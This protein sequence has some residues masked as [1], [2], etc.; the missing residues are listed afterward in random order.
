MRRAEKAEKSPQDFF[1]SVHRFIGV[2]KP[3]K[4]ADA[5]R[6]NK[7]IADN[8]AVLPGVVPALHPKAPRA[9]RSRK[10][11]LRT[12][13]NWDCREYSTMNRER[14]IVGRSRHLRQT[15]EN[16]HFLRHTLTGNNR[17]KQNTPILIPPH[18]ALRSSVRFQATNPVRSLKTSTMQVWRNNAS[19]IF[20]TNAKH[21]I[22]SQFRPIAG[23]FLT[24]F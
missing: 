15:R 12:R 17:L 1:P 21:A 13:S 3:D 10:P 14:P 24:E 18:N 2:P 20:K 19:C 9:A 11:A 16:S 7:K 22:Q 4:Q 6:K 5:R 8:D 23:R